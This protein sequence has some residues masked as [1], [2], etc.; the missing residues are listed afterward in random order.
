MKKLQNSK[1]KNP[2][3][4]MVIQATRLINPNQVE[5]PGCILMKSSRLDGV[6]GNWIRAKAHLSFKALP[7][8]GPLDPICLGS[9]NRIREKELGFLRG[10][11]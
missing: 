1:L 11:D 3:D 6:L 9:E 2:V 5:S 7:T 4:W 8:Q 10:L